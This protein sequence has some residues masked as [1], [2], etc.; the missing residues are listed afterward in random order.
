MLRSQA[1]QLF[2]ATFRTTHNSTGPP[3]FAIEK[4][5]RVRTFRYS[6]SKSTAMGDSSEMD[7]EKVKSGLEDKSII[8]LDVR[9]KEER[10]EKHGAIPGSKHIWGKLSSTSSLMQ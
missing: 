10:T 3:S 4:S 5:S 7:Y 9:T 2:N 8:L 1:A 6:S